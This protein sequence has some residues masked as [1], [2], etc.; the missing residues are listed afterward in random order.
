MAIFDL[1]GLTLV[2]LHSLFVRAKA[3]YYKQMFYWTYVDASAI[4]TFLVT[5]FYCAILLTIERFILITYPH[6]HRSL[7]PRKWAQIKIAILFIVCTIIHL[8]MALQSRLV[9]N[10]A[11]KEWER[12]NNVEFLCKEPMFTVYNGYKIFREAIRIICALVLVVLNV[13]ITRRL[14]IAK[15]NRRRMILRSKSLT[16]SLYNQSIIGQRLFGQDLSADQEKARRENNTL[17]KSFTEKRLTALLVAICIIFIIGNIP[18]VFV[19]ILQHENRETNYSFQLFR[20]IANAL[21]VLNH[22]LNFYVF[23]LASRDYTQ[24]FLHNVKLLRNILNIPLRKQCLHQHCKSNP[25]EMKQNMSVCPEVVTCTNLKTNE[26]K[27]FKS[28]TL[29]KPEPDDATAA[30]TISSTRTTFLITSSDP[31]SE[32]Q[33]SEEYS[34]FV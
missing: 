19:M 18:Q 20:N 9:F 24:A 5:S 16:K 13:F 26:P 17:M 33:D 12:R 22:C 31:V 6:A 21:E 15:K 7:N 23:C 29:P 14:Q 32:N 3:L 28:Q 4:N 2:A 8:P 25:I 1:I 10:E 34:I 27:K 11:N 30:I